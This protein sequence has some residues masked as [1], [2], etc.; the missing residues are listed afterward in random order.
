MAAE[1]GMGAPRLLGRRP[2]CEALD[3]LL[4]DALAGGS[5]VAVLRGRG[6][7]GQE[8]VA[9]LPVRPCRRLA[10]CAGRRCRVGDRA[11]LQR[12]PP[13]LRPHAR[14]P[15]PTPAPQRDALAT[16]FGRSTGPAP[17]RFMVGLATLTLLAEI[18]E[19]RPL[20]CIV[21]DAQWLDHPS[22][23]ILGFVARRL[24][25][26]RIAIVCAAR[27]GVG[28]GVL[29]GLPEMSVQGLGDAD[30]RALLLDNVRGPLD[31][32]VCDQIITESRG[33]PLALLELPRT[34][35]VADLAGGFGLPGN[36]PAIGKVEQSYARRLA[37]T[38]LGHPAARPDGR[39]GATGRPRAAP[40]CRRDPRARPGVGRSCGGRGPARGPGA[41]RV[42]A[43]A[44]PI[45]RLPLGRRRRPPPR[46]S[47]A[48]RGHR[49]RDGPRS[50]R[51]APCPGD[52]GTRRGSR[53]G[54]R[55]FGEPGTGAR[56]SRRRGRVPRAGG[57]AH[58]GAR[59]TCRAGA[60]GSSEQASC[61]ST[62]RGAAT[63][64]PL[65]ATGPLG[66]LG[67]ARA[68]L[69]RAQIA[70]V[71]TRGRE[72]PSLLLDAARR[73]ESLDPA[74]ARETYLDAF[75]AAVFAGRLARS[76]DVREIAAAVLAAEWDDTP[77]TR[78]ARLRSAARRHRASRGAWL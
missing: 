37:S 41:R 43:P 12:P 76:G 66:E 56:R 60:V 33:N 11:G 65:R 53:R 28:D 20:V 71:T 61:G 55:A 36:Q 77:S 63:S 68:Q 49:R 74:L 52:A 50:P 59:A 5:R 45:R 69:L 46:T 6:G 70:F 15:G 8:R 67:D 39:R 75:A 48:R 35:N 1:I 40:P 62:G 38:P 10:R 17:D 16:V 44:H 54:T 14:S 2:E 73:L 30:A 9:G 4:A 22:L 21:D 72:A 32:A 27:T 24:L 78:P 19:Q 26:E 25:A 34:W 13:A 31:A 47:R 58:S 64:R 3:R 23:Q 18:A 51:L 7:R 29:A 42:R 57:R